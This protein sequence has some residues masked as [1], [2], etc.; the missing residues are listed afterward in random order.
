MQI[1]TMQNYPEFNFKISVNYSYNLAFTEGVFEVSNP[2]LAEVLRR[3]ARV[4]H[5]TEVILFLD[6]GLHDCQPFLFRQIQDYFNFYSNII[7]LQS[8][9]ILL[10]GG[11]EVK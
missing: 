10:M 6:Q 3:G 1:N 7:I 5:P 4:D 2:L 9:P 11:E 8:P